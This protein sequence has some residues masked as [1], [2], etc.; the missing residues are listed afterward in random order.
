[1]TWR[2][3]LRPASFR[4]VSFEMIELGGTEGRRF[5][6]DETPETDALAPTND[7]GRRRPEFRVRAVVVGDDY[8][9]RRE[10]LRGALN[11]FGPGELVHPWRGRLRVQV[12][13]VSW[14]HDL[15]HGVCT[16]EFSCVESGGEPLSVVAPIPAARASSAVDLANEA[17]AEAYGTD[18]GNTKYFVVEAAIFDRHAGTDLEALIDDDGWRLTT[19]EA[20]T[21]ALRT[22][23]DAQA[24]LQ[25]VR[26]QPAY[27]GWSGVIPAVYDDIADG[28]RVL[29]LIRVIELE[30]EATY[31]TADQAEDVMVRLAG[32]LDGWMPSVTDTALY[33][34]LVDLRATMVDTLAGVAERLPRTRPLT[35]TEPLPA[36]VLAYDLYGAQRVATR[37]AE[38]VALNGIGHPGFVSGTLRVLSR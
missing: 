35:V 20:F 12:G 33:T 15:A 3:E 38:I 9:D 22:L 18:E 5:V 19:A 24:L 34:A 26:S 8:L 36:L 28:M 16:F 2:T 23:S 14:Q 29:T 25:F 32:E 1:M 27:A 10:A 4:G 13:D 30:T 17:A 37:E 7:L 6:A 31:T 21:A 11:S